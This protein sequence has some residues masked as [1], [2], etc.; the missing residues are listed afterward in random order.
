MDRPDATRRSGASVP[1]RPATSGVAGRRTSSAPVPGS[2]P[3][4]LPLHVFLQGGQT[5]KELCEPPSRFLH[6][7]VTYTHRPGFRAPEECAYADG[8]NTA[9]RQDITMFVVR[10]GLKGT[11]R[12]RRQRQPYIPST[13]PYSAPGCSI[14]ADADTVPSLA[15]SSSPW[16]AILSSIYTYGK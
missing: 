3:S 16:M 13:P 8:P 14:L 2:A 12:G 5:L 10:G 7:R 6:G 9:S 15:R 1:D 4:A 11:T